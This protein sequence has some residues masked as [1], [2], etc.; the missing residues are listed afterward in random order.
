VKENLEQEGL[1]VTPG[2]LNPE[3]L[4][5]KGLNN[6]ANHP[7]FLSGK[8]TVQDESAMLVGHVLDPQPFEKILDMCSAPGGKSTHL[9]QLM[10]NTGEII[11]CDVHPHKV[12]LIAK[13]AERMGIGCITPCL[14]DGVVQ[15][16]DFV[17]QFD[18][19]LLD[20]PCSGLGILKRKPD[21]RYDKTLQDSEAIAALQKQLLQ[22]AS[23]YLKPNGILVYSTC[24]LTRREN[25]DMVDFAVKE[26]GFAL[27]P[28]SPYLP[29]TLLPFVTTEGMILIL[30][31]YADSDGFFIARLRKKAD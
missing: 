18:K 17:G 27:E 10:Q 16:Q 19:V 30:P 6:I 5:V 23:N 9:A 29:K 13:N 15:R 2:V 7:D 11:S 3:A 21:I 26:L 8:W 22:N 31:H 24:T 28:I 4:V 14:Q 12:T 20:A 1:T 25:Q